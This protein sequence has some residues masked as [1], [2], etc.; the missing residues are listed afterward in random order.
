MSKQLGIDTHV[1]DALLPDLVGHD[2]RPSSF[3]LYLWLY[4]MTR[5]VGRKSAFFSYQMLHDRTGLS[6]RAVQRAVAHLVRRQL[7]RVTRKAA[8]SVPEYAV[9]T[10]WSR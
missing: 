9:V 6:K 5:G 1:I 2:K 4:A 7:L 8:T 10:P 3:V